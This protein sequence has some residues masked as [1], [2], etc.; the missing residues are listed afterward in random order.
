M[1]GNAADDSIEDML[2]FFDQPVAVLHPTLPPHHQNYNFK[3]PDIVGEMARRQR[4]L[5]H[6][7]ENPDK[8][9]GIL[10]YYRAHPA[11]F[12]SDWFLTYD[13]RLKRIKSVPFV[14]FPRQREWLGAQRSRRRRRR[15]KRRERIL[16]ADRFRLDLHAEV[17][18]RG[19]HRA[20]KNSAV[21]LDGADAL[22]RGEQILRHRRRRVG[23]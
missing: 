15:D 17:G 2:A 13:P 3:N 16:A 6:I 22:E 12:I 10:A 8:L 1:D 4:L 21:E 7:R 11:D 14:L 5:T 20:G 23:S 18:E 9:P 19:E